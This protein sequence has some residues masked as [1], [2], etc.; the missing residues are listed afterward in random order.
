M[1]IKRNIENSILNAANQFACITIYGSR[2]VGKSTMIKHLFSD[3]FSY[4]TLDDINA[5]GLAKKDPKLFLETYEY[6]IIID[7]IQKVPELLSEIKIII[8]NK[9]YEWL[10]KNQKS[11]LLYILTGSNQFE[12]QDKITESLAGR[13][14]IFNMAS[15]SFNELNFKKTF[16]IFNPNIKILMEKEKNNKLKYFNRKEIF[17]FIYNGGMPEYVINELDRDYFFSSYLNT[18]IEKDV[19]TVINSSNEYSF[20]QFISYVAFRTGCQINYDDISR[21]VGVDAKTIKKWLSI[22]ETS[23]IITILEPFAKNKSDR[24]IKTPKLYFM[25]TGLCAYLCKWN[26]PKQLEESQMAG[27][28]YETFVVSE[29]I[30]S[31]Y[32]AGFNPKSISNNRL[33][34]YRDKDGAEIDLVIE[35]VE[36]IYPIEIKKGI[37][38][39]S[40]N[41]NFNV[42]KKYG[43]NVLTGLVIDSRE[44][45]F[46]VNREVYYCPVS[47]IG[48]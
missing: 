44:G 34:Y 45:I 16:G 28:F 25:D 8:D 32:N 33:Y 2:Q 23:G 30:K 13:T 22:L 7:E 37:N 3:K 5:R 29:I 10:E 14:A 41:K 15:F 12:L 47:L 38:P 40:S 36:G 31:Y 35:T 27:N 17:E 26:S 42:L 4:V 46:P 48:L 18:Y 6:P 1:Y 19:K 9:K 21:A 43:Y 20:L 24:V 11:E 39:V